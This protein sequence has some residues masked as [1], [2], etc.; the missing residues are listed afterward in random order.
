MNT[1]PATKKEQILRLAHV[2]PFVRI[3]DT[4]AV[5]KTTPRYV[6]TAL[7]ERG[8]SLAKLRRDHARSMA[9]DGSLVALLRLKKPGITQVV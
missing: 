1:V 9:S 4:A 7:S 8:V 3:S 2:D 5:V 6:C